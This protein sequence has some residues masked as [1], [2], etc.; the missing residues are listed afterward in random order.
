MSLT[1][2][3]TGSLPNS[4]GAWWAKAQRKGFTYRWIPARLQDAHQRI[5]P[6]SFLR[7][8][9]NVARENTPNASGSLVE[10]KFLDRALLQTS[11]DRV[12]ELGDEYRFV[13]RLEQLRG[14]TMLMQK[15]EVEELLSPSTEG[16][17]W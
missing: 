7:L 16:W 1:E 10:F 13:A 3:K 8:I 2:C 14:K 4:R 5:V 6:R 11:L 15:S 12:N 17:V 9:G